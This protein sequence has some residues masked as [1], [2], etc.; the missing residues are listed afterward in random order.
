MVKEPLRAAGATLLFKPLLDLAP[1]VARFVVSVGLP[2]I[3]RFA[4]ELARFG[5]SDNGLK[6]ATCMP[7]SPF[8]FG[9]CFRSKVHGSRSQ[10]L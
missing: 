10:W 9:F 4:G 8:K 5:I 1:D 2:Q 6:N 3:T 7:L